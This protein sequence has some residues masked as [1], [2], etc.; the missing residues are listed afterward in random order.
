MFEGMRIVKRNWIRTK[1]GTTQARLLCIS[2]SALR[3]PAYHELEAICSLFSV[4]HIWS[5]RRNQSG[6]SSRTQEP[7]ST[8]FHFV[9]HLLNISG[10]WTKTTVAPLYCDLRKFGGS[11]FWWRHRVIANSIFV[12]WEAGLRFLPEA[13]LT[14]CSLGLRCG[15]LSLLAGNIKTLRISP[16]RKKIL[17]WGDLKIFGKCEV[18]ARTS[19]YESLTIHPWTYH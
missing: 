4:P 18:M 10:R 7:A 15:A 3:V 14:G 9:F 17:G 8:V 13:M 5:E 11:L 19:S 6:S 16:S 2:L 1:S 12:C